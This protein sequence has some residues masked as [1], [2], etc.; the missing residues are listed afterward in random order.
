MSE[1]FIISQPT[2]SPREFA[3]L[4]RAC[5]GPVSYVTVLNWIELY[6]NTGGFDGIKAYTSPTGRYRI[7]AEETE[8][9]LL[10]AGAR[11]KE[12]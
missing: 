8:R 12:M 6:R 2:Y 7:T 1:E 3:L 9:A 10:A 4:W 5:V 11:K